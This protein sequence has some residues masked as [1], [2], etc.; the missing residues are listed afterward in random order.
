MVVFP[1]PCADHI[2][3]NLGEG[4]HQISYEIYDVEG[5]VVLTGIAR[6]NSERIETAGL[7]VGVYFIRILETGGVMRFV[8]E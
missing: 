8:K 4:I 7:R 3:V 2:N 6:S 1:N 5:R